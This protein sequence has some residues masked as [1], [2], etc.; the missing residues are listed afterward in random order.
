MAATLAG[1]ALVDGR[2]AA[3]LE[4]LS[5]AGRSYQAAARAAGAALRKAR[6]AY[7]HLTPEQRALMLLPEDY[8]ATLDPGL[9]AE[10]PGWRGL[11]PSAAR[12]T[13]P[14]QPFGPGDPPP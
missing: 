9:T 1:N 3:Y 8:L 6:E 11:R 14:A 4:V 12:P 7:D 5:L 10:V 13:P 2:F